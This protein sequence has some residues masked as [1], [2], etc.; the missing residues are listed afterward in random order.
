M[1]LLLYIVILYNKNN[2]KTNFITDILKL[3]FLSKTF[4]F[5]MNVNISI[6]RIYI[7]TIIKS[8]NLL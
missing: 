7:I 1:I 8:I 2:N 3:Y 5:S 4:V 6:I